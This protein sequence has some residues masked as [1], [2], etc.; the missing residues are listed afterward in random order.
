MRQQ[1][2]FILFHY[3]LFVKVYII[4]SDV[5]VFRGSEASGYP[6][7]LNP[8]MV[9]IIS[10]DSLSFLLGNVLPILIFINE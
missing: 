7:L 10:G 4:L 3:C 6:M 8:F 5:Q 1:H 2:Y 9:N